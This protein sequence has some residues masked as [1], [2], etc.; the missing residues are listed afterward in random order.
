VV[1]ADPEEHVASSMHERGFR[2]ERFSKAEMR[3]RKT[4]DFMVFIDD[5]FGFFL[6]VKEVRSSSSDSA[7]RKDPTFNRLTDD[8][9]TATKQFRSV[10]PDHE[11]PNVLAIVNNDQMCGTIDLVGIVTGNLMLEDGENAPIYMKYAKGRANADIKQMDL[12]AW[13]DAYKA[14]QCYFIGPPYCDRICKI[15]GI[16]P[17]EIKSVGT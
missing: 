8:V 7:L 12:I 6:E 3:S 9:H 10:N 4:P 11:H 2:C 14:D 15:F 1:I 13:F 16:D 5:E 17:S